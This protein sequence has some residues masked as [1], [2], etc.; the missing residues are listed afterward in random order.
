MATTLRSS[1]IQMG[2]SILDVSGT[3]PSYT[4]RAWV[5]FN[6]QGTVSI[7]GSGNVSSIADNGT[8]D[9]T[10]NYSTG[11]NDANY[12]VIVSCSNY[13][14]D[15]VATVDL[16]SVTN[17]NTQIRTGVSGANAQIGI[18]FDPSTVNA[19]IVR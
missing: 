14:N 16:L 17:V 7:R 19:Q 15:R 5:N 8:G 10:I 11:L 9:Y 12:A 13:S 1:G 4:C 6:G 2:D 18:L 3:A